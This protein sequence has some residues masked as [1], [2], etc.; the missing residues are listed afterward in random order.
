MDDD[1]EHGEEEQSLFALVD[2]DQKEDRIRYRHSQDFDDNAL[3]ELCSEV[4]IG[5]EAERA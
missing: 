4:L 5:Q 3:V 1:A 2:V